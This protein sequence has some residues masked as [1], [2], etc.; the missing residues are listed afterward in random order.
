MD[1]YANVLL[2]P[3]PCWRGEPGTLA[4]DVAGMIVD[5]GFGWPLFNYGGVVILWDSHEPPLCFVV[6]EEALEL[7]Y[8]VQDWPGHEPVESSTLWKRL[9]LEEVQDEK[10]LGR[11]LRAAKRARRRQFK[12]C[13]F[14]GE[15]TPVEERDSGACYGCQERHLG[16]VH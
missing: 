9:P 6:T 12:P 5:L 15:P 13:R 7:R 1:G 16:V 8:E 11:V 10:A 4:Q 3:L 2:R 14:C